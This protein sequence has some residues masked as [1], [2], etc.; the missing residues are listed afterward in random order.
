MSHDHDDDKWCEIKLSIKC[1][2]E[3]SSFSFVLRP[4]SIAIYNFDKMKLKR[5]A[6]RILSYSISF[7]SILEAQSLAILHFN[8]VFLSIIMSS[9]SLLFLLCSHHAQSIVNR[10]QLKTVNLHSTEAQVTTKNVLIQIQNS[11]KNETKQRNLSELFVQ[12]YEVLEKKLQLPLFHDFM[13]WAADLA[14]RPC[15]TCNPTLK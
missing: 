8:F 1:V 3:S 12:F 7:R 14:L 4:Y 6:S 2:D 5:S 9:L 10:H 11:I 13:T 15:V